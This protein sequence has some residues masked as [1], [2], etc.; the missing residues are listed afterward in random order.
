MAHQIPLIYVVGTSYSGSTLLGYI[1]GS[2]PEVHNLGE[3]AFFSRSGDAGGEPCSCGKNS[4]DCPFWAPL[5]QKGFRV[6]HTLPF[7]DKMRIGMNTVVGRQ[8][9]I[10]NTAENDEIRFMTKCLENIGRREQAPLYLLDVSKSLWRLVHL[11]NCGRIDLKIIYLRRDMRGNVSSFQKHKGGFLLGL[12]TYKVSNWLIRRFLEKN[13]MSHIT[14]D[15]ERLCKETNS[16]L[17]EIGDY[18]KLDYKDYLQ[19]VRCRD[20][21]VASGNRGT[22]RQIA[23]NFSGLKYDD[24]WRSRFSKTQNTLLSLLERIG[25]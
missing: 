16:V 20:Y 22:R 8:S 1:L 21:H 17:N 5:H 13:R 10:S 6:R 9:R 24:S 12:F 7:F 14:V 19:K 2:L 15:Y 4:L 25:E 11:I 23:E 3:V 18:L